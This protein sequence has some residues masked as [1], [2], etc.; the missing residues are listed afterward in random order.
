MEPEPKH[1]IA[2]LQDDR[3]SALGCVPYSPVYHR[4]DR[5]RLSP[6]C[7]PMDNGCRVDGY[8]GAKTQRSSVT[9]AGRHTAILK[10]SSRMRRPSMTRTPGSGT[11]RNAAI[12]STGRST[13][14]R[15]VG[16]SLM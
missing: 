13:V 12:E 6:L 2:M 5:I 16:E 4:S 11:P 9:S 14:P 3:R 8:A 7:R 10:A 1:L 15:T